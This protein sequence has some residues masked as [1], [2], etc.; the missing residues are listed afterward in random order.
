MMVVPAGTGKS[1]N[2]RYLSGGVG[3]LIFF[4]VGAGARQPWMHQFL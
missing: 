4:G 1:G 2:A 3:A